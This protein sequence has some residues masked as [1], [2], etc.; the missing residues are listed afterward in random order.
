MIVYWSLVF[1]RFL[2][3]A[4]RDVRKSTVKRFRNL[5][6]GRREE[7][8]MREGKV[9]STALRQ[10]IGEYAAVHGVEAAVR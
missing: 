9:Y 3:F 10:E 4:G 1:I 2:E 8:G 7:G 6:S 5:Y